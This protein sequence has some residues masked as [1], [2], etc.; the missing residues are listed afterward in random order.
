M[1]CPLCGC[2]VFDVCDARALSVCCCV[3]CGCVH[4][5]GCGLCDCVCVAVGVV[6]GCVL[7]LFMMCVVWRVWVL[8][9]CV[10]FG[11]SGWGRVF[12]ARLHGR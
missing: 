3:M 4:C 7:E 12:L 5:V 2:C 11:A 6:C 9:R 1:V 8:S 10:R